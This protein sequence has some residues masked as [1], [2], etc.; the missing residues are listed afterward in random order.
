M[1]KWKS[2]I[3]TALS[4]IQLPCRFWEWAQLL[5]TNKKIVKSN[6]KSY[7]VNN[8]R[9]PFCHYNIMTFECQDINLNNL[10]GTAKSALK[11][12]QGGV[13]CIVSRAVG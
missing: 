3:N 5:P 9:K 7:R 1:V 11:S 13:E 12:H 6:K 10:N 2:K 8:L 4:I